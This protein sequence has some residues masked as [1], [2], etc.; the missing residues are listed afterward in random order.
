MLIKN[1]IENFSQKIA[2]SE[3]PVP[4]GGSAAA[5]TALLGACLLKL[6]FKVSKKSAKQNQKKKLT[7]SIAELSQLKKKFLAAIDED[8][9]NFKINS[10]SNFSQPE[11]LKKLIDPLVELATASL[12]ALEIAQKHRAII[13]NS[14]LADYQVALFNLEAS[15]KGSLAIVEANYNFFKPE[16]KYIKEIKLKVEK[17]KDKVQVL[18]DMPR[19]KCPWGAD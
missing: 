2:S 18:F 16:K 13:K 8:V 6:V 9:K 10:E 1:S 11:K 5:N 15:I 3:Y 7:A 19:R 17:S 4:A 14:V 12:T